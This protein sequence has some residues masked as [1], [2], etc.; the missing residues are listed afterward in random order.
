MI[1]VAVL[2]TLHKI[3][4]CLKSKLKDSKAD[5]VKLD[6]ETTW[7]RDDRDLYYVEIIQV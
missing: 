3:V 2:V 4:R 7:D 5:R 6:N 1:R